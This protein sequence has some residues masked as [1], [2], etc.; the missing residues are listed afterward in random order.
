[1]LTAILNGQDYDL[2]FR[3]GNV[4]YNESQA[5]MSAD[6]EVWIGES[7]MPLC[8]TNARFFYEDEYLEL[9]SFSDFKRGY[10][11]VSD[12]PKPIIG[13]EHSAKKMFN[14]I[15]KAAYINA[16]I[17][18]KYISELGNDYK[19]RW[20][21]LV[22]LHFRM[23]QSALDLR[24]FCPSLIWEKGNSDEKPGFLIGSIGVAASVL[25]SDDVG[26]IECA[27]GNA[28]YENF[29]WRLSSDDA[30][31]GMPVG[32]Y[33]NNK[34]VPTAKSIAAASYSVSQNT[35]NPFSKE[36]IITIKSP[37]STDAILMIYNLTGQ[38]LIEQ[39]Q[40]ITKGRSNLIVDDNELSQGAYMY[41]VIIDEYKSEFYR[42]IKVMK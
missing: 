11:F 7:G 29:N 25:S 9:E 41:Q 38:L 19:G 40:H 18:L 10:D 30:P 22:T 12:I 26:N 36:T 5:K 15:G 24:H 34:T 4:T 21:R 27:T 20:S 35:P 3:F 31:F 32:G 23:K 8:A 17:E 1:M 39:K 33:C 6:I 42:M 14:S 2:S 37:K 13:G 28:L 16:G